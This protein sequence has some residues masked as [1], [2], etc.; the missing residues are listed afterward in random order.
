LKDGVVSEADRSALEEISIRNLGVIEN[1]VVPFTKGL[2]VLTGETGAGKTM[3]LTALALILGGKSDQDLI[4]RGSERLTASGIFRLSKKSEPELKEL[5]ETHDPEIE[6][7]RLFFT[8]SVSSDGKARANL[9]GVAVP[10]SVLANFGEELIEIHGQSTNLRLTKTVRQ[11]ELLD[12]YAGE[13][14]AAELSRYRNCY[15]SYHELSKNIAELK[16]AL[17]KRDQE[18]AELEELVENY[19]KIRPNSGEL[20]NIENDISR[21]DSIEDLRAGAA[22]AD[23]VLN[24]ESENVLISLALARRSLESIKGKDAQLDEIREAL[25]ESIL[26]LSDVAADLSRYTENLDLDPNA[27]ANAQDRRAE[28]NSLIKKFGKNSDKYQAL[29]EIIVDAEKAKARI[30]DLT[31]GE[32]RITELVKELEASFQVLQDSARTI[33]GLRTA[34]AKKLSDLVTAEVRQLAMPHATFSLKINTYDSAEIKNY[35]MNGL[36]E[37]LMIFASHSGGEL[38]PIAKAASGG[39]LSRLM[40]A[41]EV[42]I[43]ESEPLGTY[44]FDEVDAGIGGKAAIE[45]GR[46]LSV[47]SKNAQVIVVTHLAQVAA[48]ADNHLVVI[49]SE[50]GAI[51]ESSITKVTGAERESEIA[52]MLSGQEESTIAK[53]HAK[54]LLTIVRG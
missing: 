9:G 4:R 48:W 46:R 40:L 34:S 1:A 43:A 20:S 27:L 24:S 38:L 26:N 53:E 39:E 45:V 32:D 8:R 33:S 44:V 35:S 29:E 15:Q 52:R 47:L 18:I 22:M 10:A 12:R 51:T 14:F 11:R 21:L 23:S 5:L 7:N 19:A 17:K 41:L 16:V 49:K 30:S 31:G 25:V 50:S 54:E 42:V 6:N 3:V 36:D 2:N 13:K 28:L 37:I